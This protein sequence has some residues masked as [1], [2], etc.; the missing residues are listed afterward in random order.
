MCF[1]TTVTASGQQ[2]READCVR[3]PIQKC[4]RHCNALALLKQVKIKKIVVPH[5]LDS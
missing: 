4:H 1:I 3:L 5:V 2:E